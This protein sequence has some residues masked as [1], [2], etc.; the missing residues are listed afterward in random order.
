MNNDEE[1]NIPNEPQW[2]DPE[3]V[4]LRLRESLQRQHRAL[5][6][7][8]A[9]TRAHRAFVTAL[10]RLQ[11]ARV[12]GRTPN[13]PTAAEHQAIAVRDL[14]LNR[15]REAEAELTRITGLSEAYRRML[16]EVEE[17][18]NPGRHQAI[19][20]NPF[21][22]APRF[23]EAAQVFRPRVHASHSQPLEWVPAL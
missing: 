14:A 21:H 6:L 22:Q 4:H 11:E 3:A 15:Q 7:A 16:R 17:E 18:Q 5:H 8:T 1:E 20:V 10:D 19:P 13:R 9:A 2:N 23:P 12:N